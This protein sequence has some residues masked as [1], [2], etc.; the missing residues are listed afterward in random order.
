MASL[1]HE[2]GGRIGWKGD[3]QAQEAVSVLIVGSLRPAV[4]QLGEA[5]PSDYYCAWLCSWNL[6]PTGFVR[7]RERVI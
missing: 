7:G 6:H 2:L 4:V 5:G 1:Q 3:Q